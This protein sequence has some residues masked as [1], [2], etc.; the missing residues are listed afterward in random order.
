MI[1]FPQW[2][3]EAHF[4]EPFQSKP[5][6]YLQIRNLGIRLLERVLLPFYFQFRASKHLFALDFPNMISLPMVP[7]TCFLFIALLF[8]NHTIAQA[9]QLSFFFDVSCTKPS[10]ALPR[11]SLELSTCLVPIGAYGLVI[12]VYPACPDGKSASMIM[13]AVLSMNTN[14]ST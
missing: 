1:K 3:N 10:T 7:S 4:S 14:F 12:N 8:P 5:C 2:P 9:G 6:T 11:A 13:Y